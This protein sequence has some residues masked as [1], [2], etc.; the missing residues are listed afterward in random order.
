MVGAVFGAI[1][2]LGLN[3]MF[4]LAMLKFNAWQANRRTGEY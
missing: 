1:V 4:V 3:G 2:R